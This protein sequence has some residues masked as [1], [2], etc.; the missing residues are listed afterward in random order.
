VQKDVY[1]AERRGQNKKG[2]TRED[3]KSAKKEKAHMQ[4]VAYNL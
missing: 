2:S 3:G 1:N 4:Q